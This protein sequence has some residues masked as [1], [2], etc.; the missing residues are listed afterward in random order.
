MN[1]RKSLELISYPLSKVSRYFH[2]GGDRAALAT[3]EEIL[4]AEVSVVSPK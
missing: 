3:V 4:N 1:E 2:F